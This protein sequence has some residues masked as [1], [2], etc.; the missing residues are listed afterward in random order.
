MKIP[1]THY[2]KPVAPN[3]YRH[4]ENL[5]YYAVKK[6]NGKKVRHPLNTAD[7]KTADRKLLQWLGE[8]Q[9]NT[10]GA[11]PTCDMTVGQLLTAFAA[12]RVGTSK[13]TQTTEAGITKKMRETF[14]A[15]GQG[16]N[17]LVSRVRHSHLIIWLATIYGNE[18]SGP[19]MR[20]STY[21]RHRLFLIQLFDFAVTETI[22]E[23][24]PF[25]A[26][27]I[28]AKG[29]QRV[30]RRVPTEAEF[31]TIV[32]EIRKPQWKVENK[33]RCGGQRPLTQDDAAD[34][35]EYLG[36]AGVG[37][38]EASRLEWPDV[39]WERNIVNYTR[40][41][42]GK[43]FS[44]PIYAWLRPL[45]KRLN[46]ESK[47]KAGRIFTIKDVKRSLNG[48]KKRL[49][50][51]NFTQRSLR[52]FLIGRLWKASVDVKVIALWQG[53]SD[54]GKLIMDTYTEV[55]GSNDE[56][57]QRQQLAKAEGKIVDFAAA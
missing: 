10:P 7:R 29:K 17:L 34:F 52:A 45:L 11:T 13:S 12:A 36:L 3:L 18:E 46:D 49:G 23:H 28:P 24:S 20:H 44:H 5:T 27:M 32:Q 33:G 42:T 30:V 54:G 51:P 19:K 48:A 40:R 57:Y 26:E 39:D 2:L 1:L 43:P 9:M 25:D 38:A 50:Y 47:T 41:K 22:I 53:H 31:R 55:F 14:D 37:Q 35:A 8:Q 4:S 56:D 6:I 15:K 16:M 21:N